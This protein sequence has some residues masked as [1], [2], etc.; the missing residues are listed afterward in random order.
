M[1]RLRFSGTLFVKVTKGKLPPRER[2]IEPA[3]K[4]K[5]PEPRTLG[6]LAEEVH[7]RLADAPLRFPKDFLSGGD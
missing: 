4:P 7:K 5:K 1:G 6:R 2:V 3:E